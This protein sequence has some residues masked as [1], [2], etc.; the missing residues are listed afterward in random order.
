MAEWIDKQ[1]TLNPDA[2]RLIYGRDTPNQHVKPF[3]AEMNATATQ[4]GCAQG[5]NDIDCD[6]WKALREL[7][8]ASDE[9]HRSCAALG[10]R[11]F[12]GVPQTSRGL[13]TRSR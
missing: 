13:R 9:S 5:L 8:R 6:A 7:S 2:P 11:S 10:P 4:S 12:L 3:E 1:R